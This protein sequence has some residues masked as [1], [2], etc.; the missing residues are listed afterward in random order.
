MSTDKAQNIYCWML[1]TLLPANPAQIIILQ[2][3]KMAKIRIKFSQ[4]LS[5]LF[6]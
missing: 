5:D 6:V 1:F 2:S 3:P 4:K